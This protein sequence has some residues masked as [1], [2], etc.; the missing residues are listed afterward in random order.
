MLAV[1]TSGAILYFGRSVLI[2]LSFAFL[3]SCI[4]YP[5]VKSFETKGLTKSWAIILAMS[6]LV[7][8]T[9]LIFFLIINAL[10]S[11]IADWQDLK[12]QLTNA[13]QAFSLFLLDQFNI[14]AQ[15]QQQWLKSISANLFT[16]VFEVLKYTSQSLYLALLYLVLIPLLAILILFYRHNLFAGLLLLLP[17]QQ[18]NSLRVILSGTIHAYYNFIKGMLLVYLIVGLLNSL[19]LFILGIPHAFLFGFL[20]SIL[21]FIPYV[22]IMIASL[23]PISVSWITFGSWWYPAG[24]IAIFAFVQY[25][26]ANII[27]PFAV[28]SRLKLNTLAILI[29]ILVGG[30]LWGT[31]GMILFIPFT[32]ILKLIADR[33]ASLKPLSIFLGT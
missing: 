13:V 17:S 27:F 26:E 25:L 30:L 19:G 6:G 5:I 9:I 11:F 8:L 29:A 21:T 32:G 23:L 16:H 10:S 24:V 7:T 31:A 28:S 2:P 18:E 1:L 3:I 12:N 4:L 14:A 33:S 15:V 22:G 20:A